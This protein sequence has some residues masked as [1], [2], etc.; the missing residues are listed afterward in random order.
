M[1][2]E[3]E[4]DSLLGAVTFL[5]PTS[6]KS[7]GDLHWHQEHARQA[8]NCEFDPQHSPGAACDSGGTALCDPI[9]TID[10]RIIL[11]S[12]IDVR[13]IVQQVGRLPTCFDPW[14]TIYTYS[15]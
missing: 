3:K 4:A 11:V 13:L 15:Y 5:L 7:L 2:R 9:N 12:L 1:D 14:Y 6:L 10:N 8:L